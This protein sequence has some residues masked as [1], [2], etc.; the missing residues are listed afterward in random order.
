L[1]TAM[2]KSARETVARAW[3]W[4]LQAKSYVPFFDYGLN[5]SI[6][7]HDADP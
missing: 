1:R 3:N 6:I 2:G 4:D 7:Q 5:N